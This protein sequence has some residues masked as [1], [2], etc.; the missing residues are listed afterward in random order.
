[1]KLRMSD[2]RI[3]GLQVPEDFGEP[4]PGARSRSRQV[5]EVPGTPATSAG[6]L[7]ASAGFGQPGSFNP[8][9]RPGAPPLQ[10]A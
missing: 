3:P 4:E 8:F 2:L 10:A 1:M 9:S 6:D 5:D 7:S